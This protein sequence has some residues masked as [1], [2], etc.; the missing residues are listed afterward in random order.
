MDFDEVSLVEGFQNHLPL[1]ARLHD[2]GYVLALK[3]RASEA[4]IRQ[5]FSVRQES[6]QEYLLLVEACVLEKLLVELGLEE[7]LMALRILHP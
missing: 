6:D 1:S 3:A 7:V 4:K 5:T 2:A